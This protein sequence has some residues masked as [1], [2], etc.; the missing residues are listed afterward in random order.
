MV[1]NVKPVPRP[2]PEGW[3][4]TCVEPLITVMPGSKLSVTVTLFKFTEVPAET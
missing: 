2:L 3:P 1:W 4:L